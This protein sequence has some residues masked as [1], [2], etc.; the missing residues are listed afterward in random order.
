MNKGMNSSIYSAMQTKTPY[1]SYIKTVL[2]K[3][4]VTVL[5]P[6]SGEPEGRIIK[7]DP[8][9]KGKDLCIIDIW[10]EM[11]DAFFTRINK[12]HLETATLIQ[13]TRKEEK[14]EEKSPNDFSD[15]ELTTLLNEKF[16]TLTNKVNKM[17]SVA[18]IFRL[19]T[20]ARELE[21]SEKIIK[22]L[23]GKLSELQLLEYQPEE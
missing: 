16:F 5:N 23:E 22:Y 20:V 19:V 10:S 1:K 9:G 18:P 15:E 7:G 17:T 12:R 11:E 8:R 4:Y 14:V 13:Y 6:F 2:G 3:I 21:K